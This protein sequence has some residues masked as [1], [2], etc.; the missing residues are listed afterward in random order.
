MD[1]GTQAP[2]ERTDE[3]NS[4][5]LLHN[6]TIVDKATFRHSKAQMDRLGLCKKRLLQ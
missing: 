4:F 1:S 5:R 2:K 6:D 3:V